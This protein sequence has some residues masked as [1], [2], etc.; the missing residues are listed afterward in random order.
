MLASVSKLLKVTEDE[1]DRSGFS[2]DKFSMNLQGVRQVLQEQDRN[3]TNSYLDNKL[4]Q[5][6][7]QG[8][9]YT[10]QS[11]SPTVRNKNVRNRM[12]VRSN[13]ENVIKE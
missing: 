6:M 7:K 8:V 3:K 2:D 5:E 13:F 1:S 12:K 9:D 11:A 4:E 10:S